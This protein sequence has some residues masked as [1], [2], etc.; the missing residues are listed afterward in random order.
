MRR[1]P[2]GAAAASGVKPPFWRR[3]STQLA[4]ALV[5][6]LL[7]SP[8]LQLSHQH[9]LDFPE[10]FLVRRGQRVD[11]HRAGMDA[12]VGDDGALLRQSLRSWQADEA[13]AGHVRDDATA[14]ALQRLHAAQ[15]EL[16]KGSGPEDAELRNWTQAELQ[17]FL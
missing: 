15:Q 4:A 10:G 2:L 3:R 5:L 8:V 1:D 7:V 11:P 14:L 13:R 17:G 6:L 9:M 12:F 16:L